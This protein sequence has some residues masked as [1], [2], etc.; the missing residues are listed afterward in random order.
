M[1]WLGPDA[2]YGRRRPRSL[3]PEGRELAGREL[4][5]RDA[6][7]RPEAGR[8]DDGRELPGREEEPALE[9]REK[10]P[11]SREGRAPPDDGRP[12]S[13]DGREPPPGPPCE[14]PCGRPCELPCGRPR[15]ERKMVM[16][17]SEYALASKPSAFLRGI[18]RLMNRSNARRFDWSSGVT[19][20]MASPTALARPVRPMRCT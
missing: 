16:I 19:K 3:D 15:S 1:P 20:L 18:P 17:G 12:P 2:S 5:G 10:P 7:G 14:R 4:A 8:E 6:D 11:A 9:P 13:R